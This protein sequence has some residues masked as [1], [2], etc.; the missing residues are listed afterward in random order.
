MVLASSQEDFQRRGHLFMVADGM[1]AHAAGELA[2]KMAAD[3]VPLTYRKLLDHSP[4][5]AFRSATLDANHQIHSRGQASEDFRGM[6]T[7]ASRWCCCRPGHW[8]PTSATAARTG[9]AAADSNS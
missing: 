6:G 4:P 8:W 7:T 1:G 5:E 9:S 2:S 3:I